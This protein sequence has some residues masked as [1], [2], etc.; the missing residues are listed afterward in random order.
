M[1][2]CACFSENSKPRDQCF[3]RLARL[4]GGA[5]QANDFVQ[6]VEGFLESQQNMLA[7]ARLSQFVLG[8]PAD[9]IDA[10]IDEELDRCPPG[11]ARAAGR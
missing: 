4:L 7:L 6:I 8:A 2:A 10:V 1:M 5:N 9:H 11:P 3:A